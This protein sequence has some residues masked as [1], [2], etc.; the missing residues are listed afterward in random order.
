MRKLWVRVP[1][2]SRWKTIRIRWS[3]YQKLNREQKEEKILELINII[4]NKIEDFTP[5]LNGK[6]DGKYY[7]DCGNTKSKHGKMCIKCRRKIN[8]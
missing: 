3:D 4:E 8:A 5:F 2:G 7:C 1:S 6:I